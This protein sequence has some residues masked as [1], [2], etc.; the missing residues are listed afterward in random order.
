MV[1]TKQTLKHIYPKK[2][3]IDNRILKFSTTSLYFAW[4][5]D[6]R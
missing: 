1:F 3:Q 5:G 6:R 4:K 2:T